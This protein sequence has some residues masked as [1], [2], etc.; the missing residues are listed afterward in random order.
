M[1]IE[2]SDISA[3]EE[4]GRAYR[5]GVYEA[6][7]EAT[8]PPAPCT[9]AFPDPGHGPALRHLDGMPRV[10]KLR[11]VIGPSMIALGMGL[12][13][14]E[15]LLW[16]NLIA[17]G[18]YDILWLFTVGVLTQFVVISE[19]ERWTIATGESVFAGMGRLTR[20]PFW[21]WFFLVATLASFFWPGW[22]AE[23]AAFVST[24]VSILTGTPPLPWQPI[25]LAMLALIY[26]ALAGSTIVYNVLER[27]EI[28][29]VVLFVPLLIVVVLVAGVTMSDVGA[30]AVGLV[31]VGPVPAEFVSG[32]RFPTLLLA[33]AYAGSGGCLLLCQSLWIRDKG[34]GMGRYQG[35]ISGIRGENE[36]L[37]ETGLVADASNPTMLRR[38]LGWMRVAERELL[39]TFVALILL[40][41]FITVLVVA[42]TIG[43]GNPEVAGNLMAMVH[44]QADILG[45]RAG[46]AVEAAF[47]LGGALVLFSTQVGIIDTVTRITGDVFHEYYGRHT[48]FWTQK[49]TF[50]LFLTVLVL[51]SMAIIVAS[52]I[53]GDELSQLQPDVLL[54]IAGPFTITSMWL[55]TLVVGYL[56]VKLLPRT[57]A[58]PG[59]KR[60][61][62]W[63]AV[64]LWGWFAAEQLAR[65]VI[66]QTAGD[67]PAANHVAMHPV[68]VVIYAVWLASV[69]WMT[70]TMVRGRD[71]ERTGLPA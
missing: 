52:W 37:N 16:P 42:A 8:L 7:A 9:P 64:V 28:W 36:P 30:V 71:E 67:V 25:A 18:G 55:F 2:A 62:M 50:L 31:A 49:S 34:F 39:V 13:A 4:E 41:V 70:W 65:V 27:F 24:V 46:L 66:A 32:E 21:P 6:V 5:H 12:G 57:M 43:T 10:P 20:R 11:H 3:T 59:W 19:I 53:G 51:A 14:G 47:L 35:R 68:R 58:T 38:F 69:A 56:N 1:A 48:R 26:V 40:S 60:A 44:A 15:L 63:W 29:L 54:L 45:E 22:A 23:S 61:G 17:S 33:V